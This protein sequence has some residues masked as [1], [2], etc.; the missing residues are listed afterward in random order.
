MLNTAGVERI[1]R[2]TVNITNI[3]PI[4]RQIGVQRTRNIL[5]SFNVV[6]F[7]PV[8]SGKRMIVPFS[9]HDLD[10]K[11]QYEAHMGNTAP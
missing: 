5:L 3:I 4:E 8:V 11:N 10:Y 6:I 2:E 7:K 1:H 9:S